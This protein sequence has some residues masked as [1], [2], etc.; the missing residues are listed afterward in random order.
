[1]SENRKPVS[2]VSLYPVSAAIWRN[3]GTNGDAFYNVTFERTYKADDGNWQSSSS[4]SLNDLLLL[5]KVADRAHSEVYKL[6]ANDRQAE[7]LDEV[8]YP[9][10]W[11][12]GFGGRFSSSTANGESIMPKF[13]L[14][15]SFPKR[16]GAIMTFDR[17]AWR[18]LEQ[19]ARRKGLD[20]DE[21]VSLTVAQLVGS[22][23][24]Y[25]IRR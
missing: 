21:M 19:S 7:K 5:A 11:S 9:A 3:E 12:F 6:R 13:R 15:W 17:K 14:S 8:A 4:F 25:R 23:S 20:A 22:I 10:R 18:I 16:G 2:R 1:M 24:T